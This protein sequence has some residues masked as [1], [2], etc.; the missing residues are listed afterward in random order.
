MKNTHIS[1]RV[2]GIWTGAAALTSLESRAQSVYPQPGKPI[3]L[4]VGLAAGG[5]LDGQA[6]SLAQ[7]LTELA[8][9]QVIVDNKPGASMMLS[10]QELMRSTPDGHTLLFAPSSLFAQNPHT[11]SSVPYDP[12]KDFTPITMATRGPLVLVIHTSVPATSVK[13]LVAWA[14]ANPGKLNFASFGTGT[15]SHVYAEA[16][17]KATG[18]DAVHVPYKGTAEVARDLLEGRVQA[19]FDA[20][21]TA[22][23]NARTGRI[24]IIGVAAPTRNAALPDVPT[25]SEQGVP[26]IDLTSWIAIVGPAG[27]APDL[28]AK[29]NALLTQALLSPQVR[30]FVA[31]G[32]YEVS[33]STPAGL[34][35]EIRSAYERWGAMIKQ[36]GFVKQ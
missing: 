33:P 27:M 17:A 7:R 23:Q 24:R 19:Y 12:F 35:T 13:E 2:F 31:R 36:I 1:R 11:L 6:R 21:P 8:G 30:D 34:A 26:G 10:A 18:I 4:L 15:S 9:T 16:F 5:S 20:A 14:K 22:I 28:V 25:I 3:R 29:V 32:A